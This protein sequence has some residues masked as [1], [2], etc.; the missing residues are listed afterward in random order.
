MFPEPIAAPLPI[1]KPDFKVV[2]TP[3]RV[4]APTSVPSCPICKSTRIFECQLMP[5]LINVLSSSD[6]PHKTM[7]DEE[8]RRELARE[9]RTS[10]KS[11]NNGMEWGTCIVFS[12][13][14]DCCIDDE[15]GGKGKEC[16]REEV[17]LIQ[18]DN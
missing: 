8:R 3:K 17:V 10:D 15:E 7:T 9:L 16:W 13:K 6:S 4:Y 18:W 2:V 1:T 11:E 14:N 5:N 12:C